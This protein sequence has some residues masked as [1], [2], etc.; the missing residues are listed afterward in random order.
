M[1]TPAGLGGLTLE[2]GGEPL[3]D[4]DA[5]RRDPVPALAALELAEER[6]GQTRA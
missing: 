5:H 6:A 4:A 3:A 1:G 2:E